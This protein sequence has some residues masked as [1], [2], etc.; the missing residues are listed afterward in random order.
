ME[1]GWESSFL[2]FPILSSM[3]ILVILLVYYLHFQFFLQ[4]LHN[5]ATSCYLGKSSCILCDQLDSQ[6]SAIIRNVH[7]NVSPL[8]AAIIL[9]YYVCKSYCLLFS[10][11][12]PVLHNVQYSGFCEEA[13]LPWFL[14]FQPFSPLIGSIHFEPQHYTYIKLCKCRK[15]DASA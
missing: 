7:N 14:C 4:F 8:Q 15:L 10:F 11:S 12:F 13:Y 2:L 5:I 6:C 1:D 3:V 9:D